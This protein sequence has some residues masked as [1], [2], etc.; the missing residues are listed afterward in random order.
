MIQ[1]EMEAFTSQ[2]NLK[3]LGSIVSFTVQTVNA[4]ITQK[5]AIR[6]RC[7]FSDFPADSDTIQRKYGFLYLGELLERY[8]ERF[9]MTPQDRRAIALAL[10]YTKDIAADGMF[11]GTQRTDFIQSVERNASG[12]IYLTGALYLLHEG[13][14][15][16]MTYENR[17]KEWQYSKTEELLFAMS[18]FPDAEQALTIFKAQLSHLLGQGRTLPVLRNTNIFH[19]MMAM[20]FPLKKQLK[21]KNMTVVRAL[22]ALPVSFVR[23]GSKP[24]G[25]LREYG[26]TPLEIAYANAMAVGSRCVPGGPSRVSLM[27]EKIVVALFRTVLAHE[28]ALPVAVY[29]QL[30]KFYSAYSR[31]DIKYCGVNSLGAVLQD[32]TLIQT[33]ETMVWFIGRE[34]VYH[35]AV[36]CFDIMDQ[37]WDVLAAKLEPDTYQ[38]LFEQSL[39]ESMDTGELQC[40]IDR[41]NELTGENYLDCYNTDHPGSCFSLL[42]KAGIIDLWTAF[43]NSVAPDGT[44]V[45]YAM[46]RRIEHYVEGIRTVQAFRFLGQFLPKYGFSGLEQYIGLCNRG[47]NG[48]LWRNKG[49]YAGEISLTLSRDF[50]RDDPD[51]LLLM[52]HWA[53]EYFFT[54][55]PEQYLLFVLALLENK[56]AASLLSMED[57]RGLYELVIG[58]K[59]IPD[60][61]VRELKRLYQTPEEQKMEQEAKE[62]A[63]VENKRLKHLELIR[64]IETDYADTKDGTV[65]SVLKFL[66]RHSYYGERSKISARVA[67]EGLEPLLLGKDYVLDRNE[68]DCFLRTCGKLISL[69]IM[70]WAEIQSCIM[71]IKEVVPNASDCDSAA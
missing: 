53:E 50:L 18:L 21:S 8:E 1:T 4:D 19:R 65:K 7:I 20:L 28:E 59:E 35:P 26:Y 25:Y 11:V 40:R 29:K 66:D 3:L 43:Q 42:V 10:G 46:L 6:R 37:K 52:L 34:S 58:L 57:R 63:E 31:F 5:N 2:I 33:P 16:G 45:T 36:G 69:D 30:T 62:A 48:D 12:D 24:Y 68:A 70:D 15:D 14:S 51:G 13:Q 22:L 41:Y 54:Q 44:V 56:D 39:S 9:G 49:Y 17:L 23:E 47:F 55:E 64:S 61:T 60:Y 27:M 38:A 67:Y 32:G 71:K